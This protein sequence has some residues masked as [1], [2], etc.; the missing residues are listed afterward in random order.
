MHCLR[1]ASLRGARRRATRYTALA[2]ALPSRRWSREER[3]RAVVWR[4][5]RYVGVSTAALLVV[6]AIGILVAQRVSDGPMG[7]LQG[8]RFT[9]G[10][11]VTRRFEDWSFAVGKMVELE[12]V[13]PGT[14]RVAGFVM[15]DGVA[16]MTCDLGFMWSRFEGRRRLI[17]HLI[18]LVEHWHE[19]ALQDGRAL[20]RIE[21]KLYPAGFVRVEDPNLIGQLQR[22]VEELARSY[23]VSEPLG[24]APSSPPNDIWF[25]RMDPRSAHR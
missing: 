22:R 5:F 7:P 10:E 13:G 17:P 15:H 12:L 9:T 6:G 20:L 24:P 21:G 8:G 11:L 23:L 18:H 19:D 1:F 4:V 25:F 16:Y 2:R 3:A 14:S